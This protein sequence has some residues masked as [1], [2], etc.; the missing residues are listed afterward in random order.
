VE[1]PAPPGPRI[2]LLAA[3]VY[4]L[5]ALV[6]CNPQA[7]ART[8]VMADRGGDSLPFPI[9]RERCM[10][11][12]YSD[13]PAGACLKIKGGV[14]LNDYRFTMNLSLLLSAANIVAVFALVGEGGGFVEERGWD[15]G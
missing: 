10:K 8:A 9:K 5:D 1:A 15:G 4:W 3:A 12:I 13:I 7:R 6:M 2:A 14:D 11:G